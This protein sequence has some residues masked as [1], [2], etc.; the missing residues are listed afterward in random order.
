M[1]VSRHQSV[2]QNHNLLT[3]S[4]SFEKMTKLKYLGTRV[5]IKIVY[6]KELRAD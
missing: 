2:G 4:M 3:A 1:V 5:K 6:T